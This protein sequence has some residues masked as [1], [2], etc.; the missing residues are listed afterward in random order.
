MSDDGELL[1]E[2]GQLVRKYRKAGELS[3]EA[4]AELASYSRTTIV[5]LEAGRQG[6]TLGNLYRLAK[7]LHCSPSDLLPH[8]EGM[9]EPGSIHL[10][11]AEIAEE[12]ASQLDDALREIQATASRARENV[13]LRR[14]PTAA[15][16]VRR[17]LDR[18]GQ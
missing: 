3:Q 11:Q 12:R 17:V 6:V 8:F 9:A 1:H 14:N 16:L 10:K 4:L 5:N 7:A 13:V 18:A 2:F 15:D